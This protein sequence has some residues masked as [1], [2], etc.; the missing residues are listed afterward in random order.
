M[1]IQ[2]NSAGGLFWLVLGTLLLASFG[3]LAAGPDTDQDGLEDAWET[4]WF[5][6]LAQGAGGDPDGDGLTNLAEQQAGCNPLKRDSD[7][8]FLG[9]AEELAGGTNPAKA[10]SDQDGLSDF[11]ELERGL[12]PL[13]PDSDKG[14]VQDGEEVLVD[15][16]NPLVP[17]D[18]QLDSDNDGLSNWKEFSTGTNPFAADSDG[19]WL[20]DGDEDRDRDGKFEPAKGET[21]PREADSDDDGL[22][23]GWEV[24]VY[25]SDP[26][27]GDSDGD[28]LTDGQEHAL[29]GDPDLLCLSPME[30]DSDQDGVG[31]AGE[32][33][34]GAKSSPCKADSD[35]DGVY[36]ASEFFDLTDP[37][38]DNS[39]APDDDG[40]GLSNGYEGALSL[41]LPNDPDSDG[42]GLTDAQ[43]ALPLIDGLVTKPRD[44]DSDDDGILDGNEGGKWAAGKLFTG[45]NPLV[46]DTEGDGL[47]DGQERGLAA[48]QVSPKDGD[49]TDLGV[50]KADAD[51]ASTTNAR[52][53]DSDADGLGDGV[54]DRDQD[55]LRDPD[56]TDPNLL[57][58]DGDAM[59]DAWETL[60]SDPAL[61]A[62]A[63]KGPL[64]PVSPADRDKDNDGDG[65]TNL[66]EYQLLKRVDGKDQANRTNPCAKDS[67]GDGLGDGTEVLGRYGL[68]GP[69][70]L[71]SDPN[72]QDSDGDGLW[73]GLEDANK[74]GLWTP[75]V[76]T[77][78]TQYDTDGDNLPDGVEDRDGDGVWDLDE[79]DPRRADTDADGLSDGEEVNTYG[80]NPLKVDSDGD[81]LGDGLELGRAGDQDPASTTNPHRP[82]TDQDGLADGAEDGDRDGQWRRDLGETSPL[83][84]DSD[85]DGLSDGLEKGV[86][87][88]RDPGTLTDPLEPDSD[89]DGLLDGQEDGDRDGAQGAGETNPLVGDTD[90]GGTGDGVEVLEDQTDPLDPK[91]DAAGDPDGDGLASGVERRLKTDPLDPDSDGDTI[92]DATEVGDPADPADSD[93]DSHIDALDPDSDSDDIADAAEAGDEL[94]ATPPVDTD[95]DG[96]P[97][98]LDDDSDDDG[99]DDHTEWFVDGDRDGLPE[100]DFDGDG[101]PNSQD[102]DSDD[103]DLADAVEGLNDGDGDGLPDFVDAV[104]DTAAFDS[105]KDGLANGTEKTLGTD[106][107]QKDTDGDGLE[108]GQEVEAGTPPLDADADDDGVADG[109]DG[110]EDPDGDGL[111]GVLDPDSDDDGVLDGTEQGVTAALGGSQWK[112]FNLGLERTVAVVGTDPGRGWFVADADPSKLTNPRVADSDGDGWDD[113]AEDPGHD[114]AVGAA[115]SDPTV[116]DLGTPPTDSDGDGLTDLE[117]I[118]AGLDHLDGDSDD[119]GLADGAEHNWGLDLDGD[120]VPCAW[121]PDSDNDGLPDGLE[122]GLTLAAP[123]TLRISPNWRADQDPVTASFMLLADSDGD[124]VDDGLED[125]NLNGKVDEGEGDPLDPESLGEAPEDGDG[126][127]LADSTEAALGTDPLDRDSDDDGVPDGEE[128]GAGTDGDGDGLPA[129]LDPDSDDDGLS[130]GLE[131]GVIQPVGGVDLVRGTNLL[132][133]NYFK[134]LDPGTRTNP[135]LGD[136][137]SDGVSDG[138]EDLNRNGL[139]DGAE[140][141]PLGAGDGSC[142]DG[143]GDGLCDAEEDVLGSSST[144]LDSDD[145]GLA[146]GLESN[147]GFDLD[148]DGLPCIL[149]PDS[150][151]DGLVDGLEAGLVVADQD[152]ASVTFAAVSDSDRGG[153]ADGLEDL[154][155]NGRVDLGETDPALAEDDGN[156]DLDNDDDGISNRREALLGS[157]PEDPD[158]DGDSIQDGEE[159]GPDQDHPRDSDLDL[160]PDLLDLDSDDDTI[161]DS[162]EAGDGDLT[163]PAV[164][165]DSDTAAD[166]RDKDS[167]NEGLLDR[168]EVSHPS[169]PTDPTLA[170]TDGGG[171]DD[172]LELVDH[173]TDPTDPKDDFQGWFEDGA[174]LQGG[175]CSTA[176][177]PAA[178][179]GSGLA[180]LLG[181]LLALALGRAG[182]R[183]LAP[184][185]GL[186]LLLAPLSAQA[187]LHPDARDGSLSADHLRP[188]VDASPAWTVEDFQVAPHLATRLG[189]QVW[190]IYNSLELESP[191]GTRTLLNS[192]Y[193]LALTG[194][195]GLLGYLEGGFVLPLSLSQEAFYP[196]LK[197][198]ATKSFGF[199]DP[200]VFMRLQM[201]D[202]ASAPLGLAWSGWLGLPLGDDQAWLG[203]GGV[204]V[205]NRL[206]AGRRI[207]EGLRVLLNL[208]HAFLPDRS[209]LGTDYKDRFGGGLAL[210]A[211]P[212]EAPLFLT[213]ELVG[214]VPA[215]RP[216]EGADEG[217]GE[218]LLSAAMNLGPVRVGAGGGHGLSSGPGVPE[219]RWFLFLESLSANDPDSDGDGLRDSVDSCPQAAEDRDDFAD[220]D[221]C[222]DEDNDRDGVADEQ[223]SCP[224]LPEDRDGFEDEDGCPEDDNDG[225]R[226]ND[227]KD[228]CP[229]ESEDLDGFQDDDGCPDRDND[230]DSVEDVLD[231]CPLQ[232]ETVNDFEDEDGCPD[233]KLA[234]FERLGGEIR[235][236]D[237]VHFQSMSS[238]LRRSGLLVL[239]QVARVLA[240][241]PEVKVLAVEGHTDLT[242]PESLNKNLSQM[243]AQAVVDYLVTRGGVAKERLQAVGYSSQRPVDFRKG[244]EANYNNRRVE[245]KV[246]QSADG[247]PPKP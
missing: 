64:N 97:D 3:A 46:A 48:P 6:G 14:G 110:L 98:Y 78:P 199:Q 68:V 127:G 202:E 40:D 230:G 139:L 93:L 54:E 171:A 212:F 124:G 161:P 174:R 222:P 57:D 160:L 34:P 193:S 186:T 52:S 136:S 219:W 157:N 4:L 85:A 32:T 201:L 146:D 197:L 88:D 128:P 238:E 10:D 35:G 16:T 100:P 24:M 7:G 227:A 67:D 115:E 180:L 213:A 42:D 99:L 177:T 108:D 151:G 96:A 153:V 62:A 102:L 19:D 132:A 133:G 188:A 125:L 21:D 223:D 58:T 141:D 191:Q 164:D 156:G 47:L 56:E 214:G 51:P 126:D 166:Y 50:F 220:A 86:D 37:L 60:Y 114:G 183:F 165:S 226:V 90:G 150:D 172:R 205:E 218:A 142:P 235:I 190:G 65:L 182:R 72:D 204:S 224:N 44:A 30:A 163:T 9:D 25:R 143:D 209:F 176:A 26:L 196:G 129:A 101:T 113:G 152:P 233:R 116:A 147:A 217:F 84:R 29:R 39:V 76:E 31:D 245:F 63:P 173:G 70:G 155:G 11:V 74:D 215:D 105:D 91:D 247:V 118:L 22:A 94:L 134:D 169:F 69:S 198:G 189:A 144:D 236:Y 83:D 81:G 206:I 82:D 181:L 241:H 2:R 122:E 178:P 33:G 131:M 208:S 20:A 168:D 77:G 148:G 73:D 111:A 244:P 234:E 123:G 145:D 216:L 179:V 187:A 194:S 61:C 41:T 17:E 229:K 38:D 135:L 158:S 112:V 107:Y 167:D 154:N 1:S 36:D 228:Q 104:E 239:D 28:G 8:D 53:P 5:G 120:G 237:K 242:G 221:G 119:D 55:G 175:S 71:G 140:S 45:L 49:A 149:D 18:D 185:V 246:L 195:V 243:R 210:E 15:G 162:V 13:A 109:A 121:D 43:E 137:D 240:E 159:L 138:A 80:T 170:D 225:D 203:A 66:Q 130:D 12:D 207:V 59:D 103:D 27:V 211:S 89:G 200:W 95:L 79:T 232:K 87:G 92:D 117:E 184:L 231:R 75:L 192:R 106:P 23:D